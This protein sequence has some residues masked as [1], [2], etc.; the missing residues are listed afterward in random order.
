MK[1]LMQ[2]HEQRLIHAGEVFADKVGGV[3][4]R[5]VH[6]SH[7]GDAFGLD[8]GFAT[9]GQLVHCA[10][11]PQ[12]AQALLVKSADGAQAVDF[13][14]AARLVVRVAV[15]DSACS[16]VSAARSRVS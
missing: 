6:A 5:V 2:A 15:E 7:T 12:L 13:A 10:N 4:R 14:Q 16:F 3:G 8:A 9:F 11:H 1:S